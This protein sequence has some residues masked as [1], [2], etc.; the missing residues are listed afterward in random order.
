MPGALTQPRIDNNMA[1]IAQFFTDAK[2]GKLP[3]FTLLDPQYEVQS[4]ENP[5]DIQVGER[6]MAKVVNAV[7][8]SPNWPTTALFINYDEGGGYYDHVPPP[9]A[10]TPDDTPPILGPDDPPGGV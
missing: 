1:P 5:Q 8:S 4:Q 2:A 3:A 7:M 6:F 10:V 9:A